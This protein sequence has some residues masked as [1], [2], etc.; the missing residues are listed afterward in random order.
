MAFGNLTPIEKRNEYYATIQLGKDVK[1]QTEIIRQSTKAMIVNKTHS[2]NEIIASQEGIQ[3]EGGFDKLS[4][5]VEEVSE[6]IQGLKAAFEFGI[7]EVVWQIEQ[8]REVLQNILDVL[9]A[10]LDTQAKELRRRAEDSYANGW[11]DD[12]LEDFLESEKKNKYDF[13]VHISLGMIYLF[14]MVNK[15]KAYESFEKAVKYARPKSKYHASLA[16][17][18]LALIKRDLNQIE[19]AEKLTAEAIQL[20][21]DFAEALYQN[22]QYNGKLKKVDRCIRSLTAAIKADKM[23]CIKADKDEMFDSVRSHV[24]KLFLKLKNEVLRECN[25][26]LNKY[27]LPLQ[28]IHAFN[29]PEC[30]IRSFKSG[31][32]Q[33]QKMIK[34]NSYFDALTAKRKL[35]AIPS[36]G[37]EYLR[38][39]K[40]ILENYLQEINDEIKWENQK[41][42]EKEDERRLENME[43][44]PTIF[45][46]GPALVVYLISIIFMRFS[47]IGFI[48]AF[49]YAFFF[50]MAWIFI[51]FPIR[52]KVLKS[53]DLPI[54][55]SIVDNKL[56]RKKKIEI[57]M[58][59][60]STLSFPQI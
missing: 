59:K 35:V 4:Y 11:F 3:E 52:Q 2:L 55:T 44:P 47:F 41:I 54:D 31:I 22:A 26:I 56:L 50:C 42:S 51:A 19:K 30:R 38:S 24:N 57:C 14:Q 5:S 12:A 7:S 9:M 36:N 23:Y 10:P 13:S 17:L 53:S 43:P 8:N 6:G 37:M 60:L 18:Y 45:M 58:N 27:D 34:H 49:V 32:N 15:I 39:C 33:I 46:I 1:T 20:T 28:K 48:K 25:T 21:P 40:I 29:Y 16:L